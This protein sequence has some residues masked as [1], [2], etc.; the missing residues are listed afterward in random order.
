M[1]VEYNLIPTTSVQPPA[2]SGGLD[3]GF[4]A[5]DMVV[6]VINFPGKEMLKGTLRIA[7]KLQWWYVDESGAAVAVP[8]D[9][10]VW[11]NSNAGINGHWKNVVV[12]SQ[13]RILESVAEFSRSVALVNEASY[14]QIDMGVSIDSM[15]EHMRYDSD[16]YDDTTNPDYKMFSFNGGPDANLCELP[17]SNDIACC[18][19][20]SNVNVRYSDVGMLKLEIILQENTKTGFRGSVAGRQYFYT[21]TE[22]EARIMTQPEQPKKE[23]LVLEIV[24]NCAVQ[25]IQNKYS[26]LTFPVSQPFYSIVC[27]L[28]QNSHNSTNTN[29]TEYD[30]LSSDALAELAELVEYKLNNV[31]S[32][33]SFPL[34]HQAT[35]IL[36]NYI[37]AIHGDSDKPISH[38]ALSYSK[39]SKLKGY[40]LGAFFGELVP[41]M[42]TASIN[43]L[44]KETPTTPYRAYIF[45]LG[46]VK[47]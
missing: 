29:F 30:Y 45:A 7:G 36:Y 34:T 14:H 38:H 9:D 37:L 12:Y 10:R 2:P 3:K 47:F 17:F 20:K 26:S 16:C 40:G 25:T 4:R 18:L 19:N 13:D 41:A 6:W 15:L 31:D 35:E 24:Q 8:K 43:V 27:G 1:S 32:N 21:M 46:K 22:L 11:E 44:L 5:G 33:I 39:L 42:T 23:P 28:V